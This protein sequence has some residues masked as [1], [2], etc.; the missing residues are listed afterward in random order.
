MGHEKPSDIPKT[1]SALKESAAFTSA[2]P[3]IRQMVDELA[4]AVAGRDEAEI[5]RE[6]LGMLTKKA[7]PSRQEFAEAILDLA[8]AW[9]TRPTLW[10]FIQQV[11]EAKAIL[12]SAKP[13]IWSKIQT[14]KIR[15]LDDLPTEELPWE[16]AL[17]FLGARRKNEEAKA[18]ERVERIERQTQKRSAATPGQIRT[19]IGVET[20]TAPDQRK[21]KMLDALMVSI[22]AIAERI[23]EGNNGAIFVF[24]PDRLDPEVRAEAIKAG[25]LRPEGPESAL[26]IMK[27]YTRGAGQQEARNQARA[28]EI[29]NKAREA[30][31]PVARIPEVFG[32]RDIHLPT[33]K[34]RQIVAESTGLQDVGDHIDAIMMELIPGEDLACHL[35]KEYARLFIAKLRKLKVPVG[36]D[37]EAGIAKMRTYGEVRDYIESLQ[38]GV[39]GNPNVGPLL[40]EFMP[41]IPRTPEETQKEQAMDRRNAEKIQKLLL[42]GDFRLD[43]EVH[44][45]VLETIQAFR[46]QGFIYLDAH[47]RNV[48]L[49]PKG[50]YIIDFAKCLDIGRPVL[51]D[52]DAAAFSSPEDNPDGLPLDMRVVEFL[53]ALIKK[54]GKDKKT[55]PAQQEAAE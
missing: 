51:G 29:I 11:P 2:P 49:S 30:G 20:E 28:F 47:E 16:L 9:E 48:M 44:T 25:L 15:T 18:Q 21:E 17:A 39:G 23:N 6:A 55:A 40:L 53:A 52:N 24:D 41:H 4:N 42:E 43:P 46:E 38:R 26:K 13:E 3:A 50:V 33:E 45:A 22:I 34:I 54:V 19:E 1:I 5:T 37:E 10:L 8:A 12:Q 35:W 27:V 31:R 7:P 32:V 14:K 36:P